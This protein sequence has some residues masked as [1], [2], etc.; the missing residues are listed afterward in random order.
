[1]S[2]APLT[3]HDVD[4]LLDV[5][6]ERRPWATGL[7]KHFANVG[8]GVAFDRLVGELRERRVQPQNRFEHAFTIF[9]GVRVPNE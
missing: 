6:D 9:H 4:Q 2:D 7:R 8:A 1:V 3:R 5:L